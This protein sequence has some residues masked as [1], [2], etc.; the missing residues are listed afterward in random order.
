VASTPL[1][2]DPA[3]GVKG[4]TF[5]SALSEVAKRRLTSSG[6]GVVFIEDV[7]LVPPKQTEYRASEAPNRLHSEALAVPGLI[8]RHFSEIG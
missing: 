5:A 3:Y 1:T 2:L 7:E 8:V 6:V 4:S